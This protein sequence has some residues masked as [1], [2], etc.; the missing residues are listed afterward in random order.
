[1]KNKIKLL[2]IALMMISTSSLGASKIAEQTFEADG[3]QSQFTGQSSWEDY[4][5]T[6]NHDPYA[7][8]YCIRWNQDASRIDPIT[9]LQG[10]GN[11]LFDWR[12]GTNIVPLTPNG[13]F[14]RMAFSNFGIFSSAS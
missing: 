2:L 5:T 11:S 4:I 8:S 6:T 1:M 12:G 10:I 7:G 9:G 14:F 13:G 3:W